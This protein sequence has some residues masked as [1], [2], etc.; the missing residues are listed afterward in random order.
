MD[1]K[2]KGSDFLSIKEFAIT[3]GVHPNTVRRS[4]KKGRLSAFTLGSGR[5][6]VYRIAKSEI[7]RIALIDLE[8]IVERIVEKRI[9]EGK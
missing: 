5:K 2:K 9:N 3:I 1:E 7:N 4:I 6:K 8:D